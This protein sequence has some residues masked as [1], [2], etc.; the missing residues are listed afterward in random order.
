MSLRLKNRARV[1]EGQAFGRFPTH[2]SRTSSL[3]TALSILL[4]ALGLAFFASGCSPGEAVEVGPTAA[5]ERGTIR[6]IVVA[7][8]TLEPERQVDVRPRSSG[9]IEK[10]LIEDG[11]LVEV[12]QTLMEIERD[13]IEVRLREVRA[14]NKSAKIE[15]RYAGIALDRANV[16]LEKGTMP[17]Q[18]YDEA[19]S[20]H[21]RSRAMVG[22][23]RA[24]V[25]RLEVELDHATIRSPMKGIVLDIPV[26]E[27]SAVSSVHSVTGGTTV[28]SIATTAA[29]HLDGMV[30]ENEIAGVAIGQSAT[31]TTEAFGADQIFEGRVRQISPIGKRIQNVTYFEV[32]VSIVDS[33]GDRLLPRMSG[34]ADIVT[35]TA[36]QVLFVPETAL[37]YEGDQVFLERL[38]GGT[39]K[40]A[41]RLSVELGIVEGDRVQLVSG[42]S[43]GD[44]VRLR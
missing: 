14:E 7:T 11:D 19:K 23:T 22:R 5:V 18:A 25:A 30:D 39:D 26:E 24:S 33:K 1:A 6:R 37:H 40:G 15:E 44:V 9:I 36:E 34:D 27:G 41:E 43:E 42:A 2:V 38:A 4:V 29:L 31:I 12:G 28:V 16:L 13:L 21:E 17:D 3:W 10:I 32:E 8:G 35:E 20:R